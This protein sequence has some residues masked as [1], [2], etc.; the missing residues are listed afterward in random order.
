M[1]TIYFK[2]MGSLLVLISTLY[3]CRKNQ[4][5]EKDTIR[6][7][8]YEGIQ[9][10][11][12][13]SKQKDSNNNYYFTV[14][15]STYT[16]DMVVKLNVTQKTISFHFNNSNHKCTPLETA[17]Q[18]GVRENYYSI[19]IAYRVRYDIRFADDSLFAEYYNLDGLTDTFFVN[20]RLF[21]RGRRAN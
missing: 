20:K 1:K 8:T 2:I 9:Q 3:S 13:H 17:Y 12:Y 5:E 11:N 16:D 7:Y 21:F 19:A 18:S 10:A 15:D 6:Q 14:W 4:E